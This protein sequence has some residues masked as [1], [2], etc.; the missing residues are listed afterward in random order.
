MLTKRQSQILS[1][2]NSFTQSKGY[3]PTYRELLQ[4]LGLSSPSTLHKHITNLKK[5]GHIK[6]APRGWRSLKPTKAV[7]AAVKHEI[8]IIGALSKDQKIELF[9]QAK[10]CEIPANL[11]S[12]A[13]TLYA[14]TI[15][16]NS[17][18]ELHMLQ[19]DLLIVE[20]RTKPQMNELTIA[21]SKKGVLIGPYPEILSGEE[22]LHI[23]GVIVGLL[24]LQ[25]QSPQA[26]AGDGLK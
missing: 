5:E 9:L 3:S 6:E 23:Q 13:A 4:L 19:G 16:D 17:F 2:L 1:V 25:V 18:I 24:R 10:T 20:A 14:F 22:T 11:A 15:K 12:K 26:H 21:H 7:K 8:P